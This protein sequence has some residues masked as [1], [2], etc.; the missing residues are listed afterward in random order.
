P[1]MHMRSSPQCS[2][3]K[4]R[5]YVAGIQ[6][7]IF[8]RMPR[9]YNDSLPMPH[10]IFPI[11]CGIFRSKYENDFWLSW[12]ECDHAAVRTVPRFIES[13]DLAGFDVDHFDKVAVESQAGPFM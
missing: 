9:V 3:S 7:D 6:V 11:R 1:H 13:F 12:M 2:G 8:V 10:R 4:G 5:R